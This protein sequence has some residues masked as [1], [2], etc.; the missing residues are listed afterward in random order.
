MEVK[1]T[2]LLNKLKRTGLS[3]KESAVYVSVLELGGAYPAKI[4]LYAGLNRST[5]YK[6]LTDL[7]I[8]G[9]VNEIEKR[10][11]YFYQIEKPDKVLQLANTRVKQAEEALDETK[12]LIPE[13]DGLYHALKNHPRVTYYEGVDA[14]TSIYKD[15]MEVEKP[16]EMLAFSR[17]DKME[18]FFSKDFFKWWVETK[19]KKKISTRAIVPDL[20]E[21][22]EYSQ[23]IFENA[24]KE[25]WPV[26]RYIPEEKF[27]Y[28][29]EI[30]IYGDSRI[31]IVNFEKT[32][33]S[34]IVIEDK[35]LY[36][37]MRTIF[38]LSW[39]SGLVKE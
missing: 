1:N 24:P 18:P 12:S 16:Y 2:I 31:S 7:S 22:R 30:T 34:A 10:N 14:V 38:E 27:P 39:N 11:K 36:S 6:I 25:F 29:G 35:G 37:A 21:N 23:R 3:D 9:L 33:L 28:A 13:I 32:Q 17:A 15:M 8:K 19:V 5:T 26:T 20:L 4:A